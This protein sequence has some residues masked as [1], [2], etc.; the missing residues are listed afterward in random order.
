MKQ[1]AGSDTW[2]SDVYASVC[3]ASLHDQSS[4]CVSI[5]PVICR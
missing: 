2:V 5:A 3:S 1:A 4:M